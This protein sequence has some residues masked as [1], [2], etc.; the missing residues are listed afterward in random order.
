MEDS[1]SGVLPELIYK[2]KGPIT[3]KQLHYFGVS[4]K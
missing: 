2:I 4:Y 3:Q 1:S